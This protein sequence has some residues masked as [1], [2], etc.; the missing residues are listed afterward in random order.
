MLKVFKTFRFSPI[1][2]WLY[3]GG[4]LIFIIFPFKTASQLNH[5]TILHFRGDYFVHALLFLPW[6][7][8]RRGFCIKP[9]GW[10][11]LGLAFAAG[12]EGLQHFVPYRTWN[13]NDLVANVL[14]MVAGF[15]I[16]VVFR[17]EKREMKGMRPKTEDQR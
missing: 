17:K 16:W 15:G 13:V 6:A 4:L 3:I 10:L 9:L 1:I 7:F 5:L 8:F 14:G 12:T 2:P 11:L